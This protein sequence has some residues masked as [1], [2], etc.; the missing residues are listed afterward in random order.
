VTLALRVQPLLRSVF[1]WSGKDVTLAAV[2]ALLSVLDL[3]TFI[4]GKLFFALGL[5]ILGIDYCLI[6]FLANLG[7]GE[8]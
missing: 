7:A 4:P 3:T 1:C 5:P 6:S 8:G 2:E